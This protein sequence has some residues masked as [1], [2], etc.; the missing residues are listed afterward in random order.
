MKAT[1][2]ILAAFLTL[3]AGIL[4]AGN[5]NFPVPASSENSTLFII[6]LAPATPA[7]ATFEVVNTITID[8]ATLSPVVPNEADFNDVA[9]ESAIDLMNLMPVAPAAA[10]F[11]DVTDI[12][13]DIH[14]LAPVA[15]AVADFE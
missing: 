13:V 3:Q 1:V 10:D 7:E 8:F 14:A 9:P 11:Y 4:F 6:S 12:V 15:P 2:T 5:N